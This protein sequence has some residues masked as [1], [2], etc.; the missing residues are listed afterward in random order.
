MNKVGHMCMMQAAVEQ[1]S[2][3]VRKLNSGRGEEEEEEEEEEEGRR[4]GTGWTSGV[5]YLWQGSV[6]WQ[7]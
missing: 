1:S 2:M 6:G 7:M 5:K 3:S 4:K